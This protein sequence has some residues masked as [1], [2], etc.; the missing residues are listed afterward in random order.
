MSYDPAIGRWTTEDPEEYVDGPNLYQFVGSN[1]INR[2]DPQGTDFATFAGLGLNYGGVGNEANQPPPLP[3]TTPPVATVEAPDANG[4]PKCPP[5]GPC[6]VKCYIKG[7]PIWDTL[8]CHEYILINGIGYGKYALDHIGKAP[9]PSGGYGCSS[10]GEI[11]TGDEGKYPVTANPAAVP[12]GTSY[13]VAEPLPSNVDVAAL[14]ANV[15]SDV[16][17]Y[18][19]YVPGVNDCFGWVDRQI[20][21]AQPPVNL[22]PS[23][24]G[25]P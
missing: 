2:V 5:P 14:E 17:Q 21:L 16:G 19:D 25:Y 23:P 7:D 6:I 22:G 12:P 18:E 13:G 1:P 9:H 4:G 10:T 24:W 3:P 11:V 15:E 8:A 20:Q